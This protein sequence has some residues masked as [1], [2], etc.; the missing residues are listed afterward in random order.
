MESEVLAALMF[1]VLFL[2]VFLGIPVAFALIATAFLLALPEFGLRAPV[3]LYGI[4]QGT[5]SQFL[6]TAIPAFVFMGV[7][8]ESS[9]ISERLFKAMQV[10]MGRLPGGL[11]LT[12]VAMAAVIAAS[13]GIV[14]AVEVVIGVMAIPI[15]MRN[16]YAKSLIA[17][18]I[19]AGGS[20]GTMIPPSIVVVIYAS[21]ANESVGKLFAAVMFPAAIMVAMFLGYIFFR[22]LMRP[23]D[24]P[25]VYEGTDLSLVE[26]LKVTAVGIL[27]AFFLIGSVLGAI[28][29]GVATPTEAASLG[30]LGALVLTIAYGRFSMSV[31]SD[32][33]RRTLLINCMIMLI[34]VGGNMFAGIFRLHQGNALV[35]DLVA[36]MALP[37]WGIVAVL[38]LI[39]FIMG[40]ILDW[41]SV[42]LITLPI[43]LPILETAGIDPVWF[44]AVMVITIQT[45]YLTPPMAP[46]IFYLRSIAPPEI[47]FG[48]MYRGVI[49]FI[50]CQLVVL[51]LVMIFPALAT[52]LPAQIQGYS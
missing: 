35:Q 41:V 31:L 46:S 12:S 49:P 20:L 16:G 14:G 25:P 42:V 34:V 33:L 4:I 5:A 1:P 29:L 36:T 8:L 22:A 32:T 52:Y 21:I 50:I 18:T 37:E 45:S 48:D 17:G 24:A 51:A 40:F 10:W 28:L 26:K 6:L 39:V 15:M 23:Q 43:F 38:L 47:T 44:A 3:Q 27:P 9:G 2:F 11:S 19:C 30:A 13:T 7:M